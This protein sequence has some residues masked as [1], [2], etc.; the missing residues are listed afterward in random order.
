MVTKNGLKKDHDLGKK[1]DRAV[2][3]GLQGGPHQHT[4]AGIAI[5]LRQAASPAFKKY[6][7]QVVKNAKTLTAELQARGFDLITG[8]TDNHLFLIDLQNKKISGAEAALRLEK[9]NIIVNKNTVP[10]DPNPPANPSGIRLG[11]PAVTTRGMKEKEMKKIAVWIE[12]V[13]VGQP[14]AK[15]KRQVISLCSR[16]PIP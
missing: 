2:F 11:T 8:G 13:L 4:I 15:I 7:Q 3:P 14:T 16:F 12:A 9:A 5:A 1:I 10:F 6:G